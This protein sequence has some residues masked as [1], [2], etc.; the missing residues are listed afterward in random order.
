MN[1]NQIKISKVKSVFIPDSTKL[2][3]KICFWLV[4]TETQFYTKRLCPTW[5]GNVVTINTVK[6]ISCFL[7]ST[8]LK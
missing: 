3:T 4:K 5:F 8:N 2:T 1:Q 6:K 7:F